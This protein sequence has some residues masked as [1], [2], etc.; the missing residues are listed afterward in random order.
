MS[1]LK[2]ADQALLREVM[3]LIKPYCGIGDDACYVRLREGVNKA[4]A[5]G[6]ARVNL[7][8]ATAEA[9]A[10]ELIQAWRSGGNHP[11]RTWLEVMEVGGNAPVKTMTLGAPPP[12][13]DDQEQPPTLDLGLAGVV[14]ALLQ[15]N[16]QLISSIMDSTGEYTKTVSDLTIRAATAETVLALGGQQSD[17]SQLM[18]TEAIKSLP[19][20]F[21]MYQKSRAA[22]KPGP[23][24]PPDLDQAIAILIR[25]AQ[26]TPAELLTPERRPVLEQLVRA[27][28]AAGIE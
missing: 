18:A 8:A 23:S 2:S 1:R 6:Y 26:T 4:S 28:R 20:L 19:M 13:E 24:A 16:A 5:R 7:A 27:A 22:P 3:D 15:S 10:A 21:E 9:A 12:R 11:A 25:A 14:S 17:Q